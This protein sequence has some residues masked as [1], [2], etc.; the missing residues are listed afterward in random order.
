[1]GQRILFLCSGNYY[2]SRFA[3]I[4]FNH[5]AKEN[6]LS[7]SADSRGIVAKLT[8]NPGPISDETKHGLKKRGIS[9]GTLRFPIQLQETDLTQADRIIALYENEHRP[10][11]VN[12][13]SDWE[14]EIEYWD[15][16]DL[17]EWSADDALARI[18]EQVR[19][20]VASLRQ[21]YTLDELE[22]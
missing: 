15:V 18:E 6:E 22:A 7:W 20:L 9:T 5:L 10:M 16:P 19:A 8:S 14:N 12:Y 21:A 4:L 3:E 13:Y 1:M 17:D 2:R 11:I